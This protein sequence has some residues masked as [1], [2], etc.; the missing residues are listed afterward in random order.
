M[1]V[2]TPVRKGQGAT[3]RLAEV[4]E[5]VQVTDVRDLAE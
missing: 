4:P 5:P 3:G 2:A 1:L